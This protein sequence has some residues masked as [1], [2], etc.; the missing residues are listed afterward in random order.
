MEALSC[1][2]PAS[3]IDVERLLPECISLCFKNVPNIVE[4]YVV[5]PDPSHARRRLAC[6]PNLSGI[7]V[8]ADD[9]F[10][11]PSARGLSGWARQQLIKLGSHRLTNANHVACLSADTLVL[12]PLTF[13]DLFFRNR[14]I[15]YFNHYEGG[16]RH[17]EYERVR[18]AN[19]AKL[20]KVTPRLSSAFNDF[21]IDFK[22]FQCSH[23]R[24]LER[25]ME[26]LHG[27]C[28]AEAVLGG[29]YDTLEQKQGFGE[30]TAYAL[31]VL[32][33]AGDRVLLRNTHDEFFAQAHGDAS[34]SRIFSRA[35][36]PSIV[37]FVSKKFP[38][39][40]LR[41]YLARVEASIAAE[42]DKIPGS[43]L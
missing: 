40:I 30:W 41:S 5:T 3:Y 17:Y 12:R 43:L 21:I 31:H 4:L 37:H 24:D 34:L 20:L 10:L 22:V 32:D 16:G 36:H 13:A 35:K 15:M 8:I 27:Y 7:Q 26:S 39:D 29:S 19:I 2:I 6:H 42:S 23:L 14:P 18:L 9:V 38:L 25:R 28:W 33:V 11:T 1:L